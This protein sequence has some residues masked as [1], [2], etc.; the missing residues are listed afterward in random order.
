MNGVERQSHQ[1]GA[2]RTMTYGW[3]RGPENPRRGD[4]VSGDLPADPDLSSPYGD[5]DWLRGGDSAWTQQT[6]PG[7][8][9]GRPAEPADTLGG[10]GAQGSAGGWTS[11]NATPGAASPSHWQP[12]Y[13]PFGYPRPGGRHAGNAPRTAISQP[14]PRQAEAPQP[15]A[16]EPDVWHRGAWQSD[17]RESDA[18]HRDAWR[19]D[20]RESDAWRSGT[21]QSDAWRSGEL[22]QEARLSDTWQ[23]GARPGGTWAG[24]AWPGE[25]SPGTARPDDPRHEP[26]GYVPASHQDDAGPPASQDSAA[27]GSQPA[28]WPAGR[29]PQAGGYQGLT[30]LQTGPLAASPP[31]LFAGDPAGRTAAS[32]YGQDYGEPAEAESAAYEPGGH[33]VAGQQLADHEAGG[34]PDAGQDPAGSGAAGFTGSGNDPAS[35]QGAGYGAAGLGHRDDEPAGYWSPGYQPPGYE[36][37]G[38]EPSGYQPPG[39]ESSDYQPPSYEP[40]SYRPSGNEPSGFEASGYEASGFEASGGADVVSYGV[41]RGAADAA[42]RGGALSDG[43]AGA[44]T[45]PEPARE[46]RWLDQPDWSAR[47]GVGETEASQPEF[48][49]HGPSGSERRFLAGR[50]YLDDEPSRSVYRGRRGRV[51]LGIGAVLVIAVAAAAVFYGGLSRSSQTPPPPAPS[52]ALATPQAIGSY[53]RDQQAEQVLDLSHNEQYVRQIDPGH[54]SGIVAAVYDTGGPASSPDHVAVIAGK[55]ANSSLADVIKS[56]TQQEAADGN[57]PM[58]VPAGP[59]GGRAACAGKGMSGICLW[60]DANTVGVLVSATINASSLARQMVV[61]RSGVEVPAA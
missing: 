49:L 26:A 57:A 1:I 13:E 61:I 45:R 5:Q 48:V 56:F 38:Y 47:P 24:G 39:Y 50:P 17:A 6:G 23:P 40:P 35:A 53:G 29:L 25:A 41:G 10:H 18:R 43:G 3:N 8:G 52:H 28:G 51:W 59:L 37:P 27:P 31:G 14:G 11:A 21:R 58:A 4:T 44:L 30:A 36:P 46:P 20:A 32:R 22:R 2:A 15:G 60:V 16:R 55:L 33:A 9:Y 12:G 34:Y 19:S 42:Y 7:A 54:V